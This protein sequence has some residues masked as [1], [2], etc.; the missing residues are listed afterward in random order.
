[1]ASF[2]RLNTAHVQSDVIS[3]LRQPNE[4]GK[5]GHTNQRGEF[6][7]LMPCTHFI[8]ILDHFDHL[9][10]RSAMAQKEA[11]LKLVLTDKILE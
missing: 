2:G 5:G 9:E 7:G 11:G 1:V 10:I 4:W 3:R 8:Q 6:N